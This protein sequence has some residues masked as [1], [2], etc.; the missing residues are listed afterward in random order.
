MYAEA[1]V[2]I[3]SACYKLA[4]LV[5]IIIQAFRYAAEPFFFAQQK[6]ENKKH[7]YVKVMN[8]FI[9]FLCLV[10]LG[11]TMNI[12]VLKYF[13]QNETYWEGLGVVPILLVANIFL[14]IYYNQSIWYK[15]SN[16][17]KFGALIA[18]IGAILTIVLNVLFIPKYGYWASAWAT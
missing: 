6:N 8:Y 3:Y 11:V 5:T 18:I 13:I 15:L 17:T 10:F 7:I 2:G 4:M 16:K 14:G 9:G 12:E 1:Q